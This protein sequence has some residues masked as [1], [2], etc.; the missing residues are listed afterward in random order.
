MK[1]TFDAGSIAT[2]GEGKIA[3][4]LNKAIRE[5]ATD[6]DDR[7]QDE[8]KRTVTLTI[9]MKPKVSEGQVY[10]IETELQVKASMPPRRS[11][12]YSMSLAAG[13]GNTSTLTFNDVSP[14]DVRQQTLDE[15]D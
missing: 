6:I 9:E 8:A 4:A 1:V 10:E 7:G 3:A 5:C 13:P 2:I 15:V 11:V 14:R 12:P